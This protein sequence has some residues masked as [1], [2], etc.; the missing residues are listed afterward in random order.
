MVANWK[1]EYISI[2]LFFQSKSAPRYIRS[3]QIF[4][5]C[6]KYQNVM[7]PRKLF[8][9]SSWVSTEKSQTSVILCKPHPMDS[10]C[11][12]T[13]RFDISL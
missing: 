1:N 9:L 4:F 2:F 8:I 6:F 13:P 10:A 5:V 11:T 7:P 3:N 12:K